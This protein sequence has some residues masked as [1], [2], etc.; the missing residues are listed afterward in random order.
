MTKLNGMKVI[1]ATEG[2]RTEVEGGFYT[3]N[4][5][6]YHCFVYREGRPSRVGGVLTERDA[7]IAI[8]TAVTALPTHGDNPAVRWSV[9]AHH[10]TAESDWTAK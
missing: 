6:R 4:S 10:V 2:E 7:R 8:N 3:F 9:G 1:T 5:G